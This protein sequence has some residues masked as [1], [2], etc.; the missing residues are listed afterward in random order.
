MKYLR[1]WL[2]AAKPDFATALPA[3][4]VISSKSV[5]LNSG[6]RCQGVSLVWNGLS[7]KRSLYL[8]VLAI[9]TVLTVPAAA[10]AWTVSV[11]GNQL[12][13]D[14]APGEANDL[15]ITQLDPA[16]LSLAD[17]VLASPDP[18]PAACTRIEAESMTCD[19]AGLSSLL[20]DSGDGN[21]LVA[22]DGN[23][24]T[25]TLI[26][27]EGNDQL[28]IAGTAGSLDG[29]SGDDTVSGDQ[30]ADLI[31]GGPGG[32]QID[33][34]AGNDTVDAGNGDNSVSAGDGDDSV[35]TGG[36][37]D[38]VDAGIGND[39]VNSGDGEDSIDGGDGND[40]LTGEGGNDAL[41]GSSGTNKLRGGDGDDTLTSERGT[42]TDSGG[43]GND[44]IT[45]DGF[46]LVAEGG[47]GD[48]ELQGGLA[49]DQL[50]GGAGG[51][52]LSGADGN[53]QLLGGDDGDQLDGGSGVDLLQGEAGDDSL[54]GG[55][56]ADILS[57]GGDDDRLSYEDSESGVSV[58]FDDLAND[59]ALDEAD[60][61]A[62]DFERIEGSSGDDRLAGASAS[63]ALDGLEGNDTLI[64][65]GADD[66]LRGG[67]GDDMLNGGAGADLIDGGDGYDGVDYSSRTAPVTVTLGGNTDNDGQQG[68]HDN[69]I[70]SVE[71]VIGG[72]G[73]D[74]LTGSR[75][76]SNT[77]VGGAGNDT[78]RGTSLDTAPDAIQCGLGNDRVDIDTIDS[79]SNDCE[80][81][82]ADAQQIKPTPPQPWLQLVSRHVRMG[83]KGKSI[84]IR[85]KCPTW[86]Y[87][88]CRGRVFLNRA[89]GVRLGRLTF[90]LR[91]GQRRS[92][93]VPVARRRLASLRLHLKRGGP[94]NA[95]FQLANA[96]GRNRMVRRP[97]LLSL[98]HK[99]GRR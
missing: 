77:L 63:I 34:G 90:D 49:D 92:L 48:D 37:L 39:T 4:R 58:S 75:D 98:K 6:F 80:F 42:D 7:P 40:T 56:G 44:L 24:L 54:N 8:L 73:N 17:S 1:T 71:D 29:G 76:I 60:N 12:R 10:N 20:V 86:H 91:P 35:N 28:S 70:E 82:L 27:G 66:L 93:S 13:V 97:L 50:N 95:T 89:R 9:V 45:A 41:D 47:S 43:D 55:V 36:G 16:T 67:D 79:F 19:T 85:A 33:S 62:S 81:V 61:V 53:D 83:A 69:V 38:T 68:E 57:G 32:D 65:G 14:A 2:R 3:V 31:T 88:D 96:A 18:L 15:A 99:T 74:D 84:V 78:L 72:A 21:D 64:G 94:L 22:V 59:G 30:G 46:S 26:G 51:D 87:G 5:T 11:S 52:S 25:P 23:V